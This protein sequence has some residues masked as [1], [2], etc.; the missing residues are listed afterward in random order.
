MVNLSKFLGGDYLKSNQASIFV[1][2]V[3][4]GKPLVIVHGGPGLDHTYLVKWLA[5]LAKYR[6]LIYYDQP[7]C[8]RDQTPPSDVTF[9]GTVEQLKSLL[10]TLEVANGFSLLTHSWGSNIVLS[11]LATGKWC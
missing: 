9:Q 10:E 2:A 8:G 6:T 7:G 11:A 1:R 5:P 3:G 4:T